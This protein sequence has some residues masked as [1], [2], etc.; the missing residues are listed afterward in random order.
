[1]KAEDVAQ[2]FKSSMQDFRH[3]AKQVHAEPTKKNVHQLR[4]A[5]RKVRSVLGLIDSHTGARKLK[6]LAK[7][8]GRQRDLDVAVENSN[9][10]NLNNRG[11]IKLK[12]KQRKK[13]RA[14]LSKKRIAKLTKKLKQVQQ[15]LREHPS[16]DLHSS[17]FFL[18]EELKLWYSDLTITNLHEFRLLMKKIR[19][20]LEATGSPIG[21]LKR[22]Q[23]L[24]GRVHDLAVLQNYLGENPQ[25]Q[26]EQLRESNKALR[27]G[28]SVI[29]AALLAL[30]EI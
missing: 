16:Q 15:W 19:Y 28:K 5:L 3:F 22:L 27:L 17:L 1:M 6:K 13:T 14:Y 21:K 30:D 24:L 18:K 26:A 23:D 29:R 8:L 10:Y 2:Y 11:L 25:L 12:K 20:V 4:I 7:V 9:S